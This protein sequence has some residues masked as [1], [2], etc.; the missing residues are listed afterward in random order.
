[1]NGTLKIIMKRLE[2]RINDLN[3]D[4]KVATMDKVLPEFKYNL[5]LVE[6]GI[7]AR[8]TTICSSCNEK[9]EF[10]YEGPFYSIEDVEAICPWCVKSGKASQK[11][12]GQLWKT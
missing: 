7:I 10:V 3:K 9:T 11:Y 2:I 6:N 5:N 1:M 8:R 4:R 12:D